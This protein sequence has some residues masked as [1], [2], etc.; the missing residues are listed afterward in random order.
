[1]GETPKFNEGI[2]YPLNNKNSF[3]IQEPNIPKAI[4]LILLNKQILLK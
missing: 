4:K 3:L 1:M 2:H